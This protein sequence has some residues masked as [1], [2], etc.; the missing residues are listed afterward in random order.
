[1]PTGTPPCAPP[2]ITVP[3]EISTNY[4]ITSPPPTEHAARLYGHR[5]GDLQRPATPGAEPDADQHGH[6]EQQRHG[7]GRRTAGGDACRTSRGFTLIE[8]LVVMTVLGDHAGRRLSVV[9]ELRCQSEREVRFV[10][11]HDFAAVRAQRSDQAQRQ[12]KAAPATGTDWA[13]GWNVT[14]DTSGHDAAH[15][16]REG[17][18]ITV[19]KAPSNVIFPG[20]QPAHAVPRPSATSRSPAPTAAPL[21]DASMPPASPVPPRG[22]VHESP[23]EPRAATSAALPWSRSSYRS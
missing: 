13:T 2:P 18:R 3:G 10:R 7:P 20:H 5:H 6:Q 16:G 1:M 4:T 14:V 12:V 15:P 8:L 21:R 23:F 11:D 19:A 9:Q 17:S 22:P